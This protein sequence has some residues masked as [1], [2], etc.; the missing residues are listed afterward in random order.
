MEP[1]QDRLVRKM[2]LNSYLL[3]LSSYL[4][5]TSTI[6]HELSY[7]FLDIEKRQLTYLLA[8]NQIMS[9]INE[10]KTLEYTKLNRNKIREKIS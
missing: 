5:F 10:D 9:N 3:T 1:I 6:Y 4:R 2:D 8:N 7:A